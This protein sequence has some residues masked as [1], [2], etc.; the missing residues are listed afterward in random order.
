MS[1]TKYYSLTFE[2]G[3]NLDYCDQV[4]DSVPVLKKDQIAALTAADDKDFWNAEE[5]RQLKYLGIQAG[6]LNFFPSHTPDYKLARPYLVSQS[7]KRRKYLANGH[8]YI[9]SNKK[10]KICITKVE[11]QRS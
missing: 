9:F 6:I 5:R 3:D 4:L 1:K 10:G 11:S 7:P 8:I 2:Q